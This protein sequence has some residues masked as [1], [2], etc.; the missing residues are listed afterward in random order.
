MPLLWFSWK[1]LAPIWWSAF[2]PF[3]EF[4][5]VFYFLAPFFGVWL[6]THFNFLFYS[7]RLL[8]IWLVFSRLLVLLSILSQRLGILI[9]VVSFIR[10]VRV[11]YSFVYFLIT[12]CWSCGVA[13]PFFFVFLLICCCAADRLRVFQLPPPLL[14]YPI[15]ARF[16]CNIPVSTRLIS[17]LFRVKGSFFCSLFSKR[18][19]VV[20]CYSV[21]F[22]D[23]D[24]AFVPFAPIAIILFSKLMPCCWGTGSLGN[25]KVELVPW[26][27][28]PEKW[29]RT[30]VESCLTC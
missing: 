6:V 19:L 25:E 27:L 26:F 7:M 16:Y 1:I 23:V 21:S 4:W 10:S 30:V 3:L 17:R 28:Q 12:V 8:M 5:L 9:V 22:M 15:S 18:G 24:Y 20:S 14:F 11:Y 2:D 29:K 13:P